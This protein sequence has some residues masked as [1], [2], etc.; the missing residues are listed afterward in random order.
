MLNLRSEIEKYLA[1]AVSSAIESGELPS[2]SGKI[3][4]II[5]YPPEK[6]DNLGDYS[7]P[8]A[9]TIAKE[10]GKKPLEVAQIIWKHLTQN[11]PEFI[12]AIEI[13]QPGFI[14]FKLKADWLIQKMDDVVE[15]DKIFGTGN[16]G[17]GKTINLEFVSANP[18]GMPTFGN[19]RALFWADTLGRILEKRGYAV[20]REYYINDVGNQV[21]IY[22][23]S[24][25][26]RILQ[27]NGH[28]IE[29]PE[30]LYQGE[31]VKIVADKVEEIFSENENHSFSPDDLNN[32]ELI[33]KISLVSVDET[34]KVIREMIE[35]L[36]QV[37]YDVW[38]YEHFVHERGE[39]KEVVDL[40]LKKGEAYE[41]E[42]AVW[43][44]TTKYGDDKDRVLVRENGEPTY[45]APDIAYHRDKFRRGY[46]II[47]DF[48]GADHHGYVARMKAAMQAMGEDI[49]KLKIVIAQM[50]SV[51]EGG[52][53]KKMSKRAG[54]SIPI[55]EIIDQVG[56]SAARF[57][58][59][60]NSLSSHMD[61]DI[62][63]AREQSDRNPVYY[64]QYAYV[65]LVSLLRKAKEVNLVTDDFL[66]PEGAKTVLTHSSE[67]NLMKEIFRFPEAVQEI[68]ENWEV[69][70]LPHFA[71]GFARAVHLFYDSVPVLGETDELLRSSRLVLVLAAKVALGNT[72]D[73]LGVEKLN[74]M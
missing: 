31:E 1:A 59:T 40:L 61:F 42:G 30:N 50:V 68:S 71:L 74:V 5:Q 3:K 34:V 45:F 26:R 24:V 51:V 49:S 64:V 12:G 53:R 65:R 10:I 38:F 32:S 41:K 18:T 23:E 8:V 55:N 6:Q 60:M 20:T 22:G 69:Q 56:L 9:L 13:A 29:F 43:L 44:K 11:T 54:T 19:G 57:F 72:L 16:E 7:S 47:A 46:N 70:R 67:L 15:D 73:L 27:K 4:V 35:N 33:T 36:C 52:E 14:N 58:L 63:L 2:D 62:E 21:R 39:V 25:L 48:W 17:E 66:P 37:H 28:E